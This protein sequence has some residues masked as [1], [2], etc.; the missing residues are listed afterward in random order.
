MTTTTRLDRVSVKLSKAANEMVQEEIVKRVH[1]LSKAVVNAHFEDGGT[2]HVFEAPADQ[3][4]DLQERATAI[5]QRVQQSLR[6]LKRQVAFRSSHA[7]HVTFRGDGHGEG[8]RFPG[9]GQ[10]ALSGD[11]LAA[12]DYFDRVFMEM[13]VALGGIPLRAPTL[14]PVEILAKCDYLKSFP[15]IVNFVSHLPENSALVEDFQK[16]HQSRLSLDDAAAGQMEKPEA[17]LSPA[18]C[19]HAYA[20]HAGD[21][22]PAGG[23]TYGMCGKC[24]RYES[25]NMKDMRRLWDFTLREV[26]FLGSR[27]EVLAQRER[28]LKLMSD[29]L[30]SHEIAAEIRTASDPFF[31]A[32]DDSLAKTYFQLSSD[33]K[34]EVAAFLPDGS[35][36]AVGS[37]N[38]HSDFFGKVF[39]CNV[40]SGGP[41]HSVCIGFGLERWVHALLAQHGNDPAA[42]PKPMRNAPELAARGEPR[43]GP[44]A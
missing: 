8:V 32:P 25:S 6:S 30:E 14:I 41:M 28:G 5:A 44:R 37:L 36:L 43:G 26:V 1:H 17:A 40:A 3:A 12:F 34:F 19:Y 22:I 33:T 2:V 15:H 4:P 38:Y 13:G 9:V 7:D 42:W 18:V 27:E 10:V 39:D 35:Q 20:L 24:F 11:P 16:R 21:T 23:I 29:F 31:V